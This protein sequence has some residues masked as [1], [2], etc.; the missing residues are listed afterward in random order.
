MDAETEN[1]ARPTSPPG[2]CQKCGR[3]VPR[4]ELFEQAGGHRWHRARSGGACGPVLVAWSYYVVAWI[5]PPDRPGRVKT[6]E[7]ARSRP[8]RTAEDYRAVAIGLQEQFQGRDPSGAVLVGA[9]RE[10]DVEVISAQLLE[11]S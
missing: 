4:D 1:G 6:F 10:M 2:Q 11:A 5:Q 7:V 3:D 9:H 8:I